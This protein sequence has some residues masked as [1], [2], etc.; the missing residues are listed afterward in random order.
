MANIVLADEINRATP[1]TQ[2]SLLEAMG[3]G[4][5]TV[6]GV[7][8]EL[9]RPFMVL[10]TQNPVELE[11]TYPLPE[12]QLDRFLLRI[13]LGYPDREQEQQI[14]RRF[15]SASPLE[16]LL[17][18]ASKE[19]IREMQRMAQTVFV[20]DAALGYLVDVV[21]ATRSHPSIRLAASPR[22]GSGPLSV[23]AGPGRIAR[24]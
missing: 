9:P 10:A 24:S 1:R 14:L 17:P 20:S 22:A 6:D 3:E 13:E 21:R 15:G 11:G 5:V 2:S 12:A 23:G 19:Q 18:T 16:N 7:T 4:Q 8:R